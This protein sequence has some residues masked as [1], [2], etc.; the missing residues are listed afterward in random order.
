MS[1]GEPAAVLKG[2]MCALVTS[3]LSKSLTQDQVPYHMTNQ[4]INVL[5]GCP[6]GRSRLD[7]A[8][9]ATPGTGGAEFGCIQLAQAHF[10]DML[11]PSERLVGQITRLSISLG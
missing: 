5:G 7:M 4:A 9:V 10:G 8:C 2:Y 3:L 11:M 6:V 1:M